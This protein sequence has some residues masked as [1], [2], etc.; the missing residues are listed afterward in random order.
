M[1]SYLFFHD[2]ILTDQVQAGCQIVA[3]RFE[4]IDALRELAG[5]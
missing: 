1:Y 2:Y 4:A 5:L 3:F